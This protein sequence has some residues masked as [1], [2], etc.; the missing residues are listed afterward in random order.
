MTDPI[1]AGY[2]MPKI[3]KVVELISVTSCAKKA[4]DILYNDHNIPRVLVSMIADYHDIPVNSCDKFVIFSN[5]VTSLDLIRDA[6]PKEIKGEM[7]SGAV[8]P[9]ERHTIL[10]KFK[11]D[12]D[13]RFVLATYKT[14][15]EGLDMVEATNC[16]LLE[17][18]WNDS[19]HDQA[20][21]RIFRMGQ[22]K[23]VTIYTLFMKNTIEDRVLKICS[24]KKELEVG[25][26]NGTRHKSKNTM[27]RDI[28]YKIL[29]LRGGM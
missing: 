26:M 27:S 19:T 3:K 4:Y 21:Y 16:V 8:K 25:F 14:G 10:E 29:G 22:T 7:I 13:S 23:N 18:W 1:Q 2:A 6:M 20:K 9:A 28:L 15:G 17:P 12:P 24:D 11:Q 5:F